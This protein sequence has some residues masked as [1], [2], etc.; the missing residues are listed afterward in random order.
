MPRTETVP[1]VDIRRGDRISE[2]ST[3]DGPFYRVLAADPQHLIIDGAVDGDP[4]LPI[5]VPLPPRAVVIRLLPGRHELLDIRPADPRLGDA[6]S[7]LRAFCSCGWHSPAM[8]LNFLDTRRE[9]ALEAYQQH[10]DEVDDLEQA[11]AVSA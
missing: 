5:D 9:R 1:A 10:R 6:P 7:E 2:T 4:E 3:P 8:R 11:L